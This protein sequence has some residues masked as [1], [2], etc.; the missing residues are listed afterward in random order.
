MVFGEISTKAKID[1]QKV[2][3]GCIERIGYD[4]SAKGT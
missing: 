3:R 1:F 2:I 4:S